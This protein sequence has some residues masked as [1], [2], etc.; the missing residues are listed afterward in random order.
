[1]NTIGLGRP[2]QFTRFR[3]TNGYVSMLLESVWL[4]APYLHNGSVPT[5][6]DLLNRPED[7]PV[8]FYRGYDVYDY[9]NVGFVTT[10]PE[11]VGGGFEYRTTVRGNGN[12]GHLYGTDLQPADKADLLEFLKTR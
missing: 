12:G 7:R 1:M 10:G 8:L 5:L 4:R 11:A 9:V 6:R 2:W 3:K